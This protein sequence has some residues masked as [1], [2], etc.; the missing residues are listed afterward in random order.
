MPKAVDTV[1]D[2]SSHARQVDCGRQ[3]T[4]FLGGLS[5]CSPASPLALCSLSNFRFWSIIVGVMLMKGGGI[6]PSPT[7]LRRDS[8]KK[9][10]TI[11]KRKGSL[12]TN[13]AHKMTGTNTTPQEMKRNQNI[14]RHPKAPAKIPP[15]SGPNAG[16]ILYCHRQ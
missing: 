3:L 7:M 10:D 2:V 12:L 6:E 4:F 14:E 13:K 9:L 15:S 16:P 11:K 8:G 5:T 1:H